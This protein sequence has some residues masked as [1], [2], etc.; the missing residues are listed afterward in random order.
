[1]KCRKNVVYSNKYSITV[2]LP[3]VVTN[4]LPFFICIGGHSPATSYASHSDGVVAMDKEG[5]V[6]SMVHTI[7]SLPWGTGLFV[8]GIA[9]PHS[10]AINKAYIK[11]LKSGSR[12]NSELQPAIVFRVNERK[13]KVRNSSN[14]AILKP[15]LAISVVGSS[16]RE[17]TP[18][19]IT[20][21]LDENLNPNQALSRP[22]FMLPSKGSYFQDIQVQRCSIDQHVLEETR[23]KGQAIT[24][25]DGRTARFSYGLGVLIY[26][27]EQSV[28][29]AATT[30]TID[31]IA[32][33]EA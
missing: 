1:M 13:D 20:S 29:Y 9:L 28:R 7:N 18:Q 17:V 10:A 16:L 27:D 23:K 31:G 21:V 26:V 14:G 15:A 12:L 8:H 6:C 11:Q 19:L 22:Q 30:P 4:A 25:I 5:N 3:L 24:A 32:E 33:S 2:I